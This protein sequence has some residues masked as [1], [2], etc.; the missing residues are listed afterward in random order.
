M[1][2]QAAH[3]SLSPASPELV[4]GIGPGL[5]HLY[6]GL[7]V[8]GVVVSTCDLVHLRMG[9]LQFEVL[10]VELFLVDVG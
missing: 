6:A 2:S 1:P 10:V 8:L 5:N 9:E 3:S 7:K 4:E